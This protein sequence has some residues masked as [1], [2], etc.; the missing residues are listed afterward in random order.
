MRLLIH[1]GLKLNHVSKIG[2]TYKHIINARSTGYNAETY[3]IYKNHQTCYWL[4]HIFIP[5]SELDNS[6]IIRHWFPYVYLITGSLTWYWHWVDYINGFSLIYHPILC[7]SRCYMW[8]ML[9]L[10]D[11][12]IRM[13]CLEDNDRYTFQTVAHLINWK[14]F[15]NLNMYFC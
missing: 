1:A 8:F 2:L 6:L 3:W 4:Y 13:S 12:I 7:F 10:L 11:V 14:H 15:T 9:L 5:H